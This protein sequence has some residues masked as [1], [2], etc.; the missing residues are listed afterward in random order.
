MLSRGQRLFWMHKPLRY[1]YLFSHDYTQWAQK[2][3]G[4][5]GLSWYLLLFILPLFCNNGFI[6]SINDPLLARKYLFAC[7][8]FCLCVNF[9]Y[10]EDQ[11]QLRRLRWKRRRE[12]LP[13]TRKKSLIKRVHR[14]SLN[15]LVRFRRES[16]VFFPQQNIQN[17]L[18]L[19]VNELNA[20]D[21][22]VCLFKALA[23]TWAVNKEWKFLEPK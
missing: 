21:E 20:R 17:F 19:G 16:N 23:L 6:A 9:W 10:E 15:R 5:S 4:R 1:H 11:A 13:G 14:S 18:Q 8:A 22:K 2:A 12:W 3:T 7:C